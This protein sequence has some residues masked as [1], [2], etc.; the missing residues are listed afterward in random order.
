M[1]YGRAQFTSEALADTEGVPS[2]S[3]PTKIS[4]ASILAARF[5]FKKSEDTATISSAFEQLF[6]NAAV[7][8][9]GN[10]AGLADDDHP[11]YKLLDGRASDVTVMPNATYTVL[12][13]DQLIHTTYTPTGPITSI[14]IPTALLA[15]RKEFTIVDGGGNCSVNNIT[16]DT[17][18]SELIIGQATR[19]FNIDYE[20]A[21]F[22]ND[23][24]NW[25]IK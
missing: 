14:T 25:F 24:V 13:T 11:Q 20:S 22:Y 1:I 18:G 10:L 21:T 7:T 16:V 6:A 3:L 9:H 5:T 15:T 19:V 23:G 8:D 17:E 12:P 4:N 2:T